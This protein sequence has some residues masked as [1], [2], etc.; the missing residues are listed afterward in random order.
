MQHNTIKTL[1][2]NIARLRQ[3][4]PADVTLVCV[5]KYHSL[6]E[7][8]AVYDAGERDFAE[9][10][11]QELLQK[12]AALSDDVRWHFIGHL[13]TN[14]VRQLVPFVHLIQSVDSLHLLDCISREAV[15]CGREVN[16]LLELHVARE[17]TKTGFS[18]DDTDAISA[19]IVNPPQGVAV[20][21]L[22][23]MASHTDD[24]SRIS[25]DFRTVA[26]LFRQLF[27]NGGILSM[28]MSDDYQLAI[29]EGAN[30]VRIGS[31]LFE[32]V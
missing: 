25:A 26:T 28:G 29:A 16:V 30:M 23:A 31:R 10:R 6:E 21:G 1:Q 15:R 8:Q 24:E 7:T 12:K 32:D 18:L 20:R 17:E 4:L 9:S 19:I 22:M 3:T 5:T 27:P 14:K 13:Q 11:L 2:S